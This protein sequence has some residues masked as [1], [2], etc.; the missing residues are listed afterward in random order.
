ML[1]ELMECDK[2]LEM[3]GILEQFEYFEERIG[4][5]LERPREIE[6]PLL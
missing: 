1:L 2:L 3:A 4:M 6:R 5:V